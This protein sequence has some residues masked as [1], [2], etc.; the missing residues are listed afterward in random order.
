MDHNYKKNTVK[1]PHNWANAA[2]S[3][4]CSITMCSARQ[5]VYIYKCYMKG[6]FK[7]IVACFLQLEIFCYIEISLY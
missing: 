4:F 1:G 5:A 6:F 3:F 7:K 2:S